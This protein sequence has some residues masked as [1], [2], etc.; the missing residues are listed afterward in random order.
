M[1]LA[2]MLQGQEN[3]RWAHARQMGVTGAVAKLSSELTDLP[4]PYEIAGLE[5]SVARYV[6]SGFAIVA[7]EG[8]QFDMSRIK[9]GLPGR[10]E[11][12]ERYRQMLRNMAAVGIPTLVYN[13]MVGIGAHRSTYSL[14]DRGDAVVS[15]YDRA[16]HEALGPTEFGQV[17]AETVFANYRY[18]IEAVLPVAEE[19]G[20]RMG[21]HPDDPPVAV[22]R[23]IG[24]PFGT[25]AGCDRAL[26][27]SDSPSHGITFCQGSFSSGG[28]DVPALLRRW[29]G[30]IAFAHFREVRG[31]PENF[32]E[33]FPD[34]GQTNHA[35]LAR[36]YV[37]IG[38]DGCIRPDHAPAMDGDPVAA[39][40][41]VPGS[42]MAYSPAGMIF[43]TGYLRGVFAG[44]G[45]PLT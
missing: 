15:G 23:G 33:T 44:A 16:A 10:D 8:D 42:H 9:R 40:G 25:G 20:I 7:L 1:R 31:G 34:I 12:I 32:R 3:I 21:L 27:L 22:L 11:D 39:D 28:E 17:P 19:V 14:R 30:R 45:N 43:T 36:T 26:A 35:A 41:Y 38:Y 13:F 2:M 18:F 6:Q 24:R 29:A 5:A 37:E 4:P